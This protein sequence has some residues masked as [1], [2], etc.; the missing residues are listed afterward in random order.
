MKV[1]DRIEVITDLFLGAAYADARFSAEEKRAVCR[2]L[3]DL[4]LTTELPAAVSERIERFDPARFNLLAAAQD[5]VSDPPMNKRRLLELVAQLC[6]A[7]GELDFDEDEYLHSLAHALGMEPAEYQ[8][9]VLDY[10][11]SD[12]RR[13]FE[14]IR[15]SSVDL[16][17]PTLS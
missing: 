15:R 4:L 3:C 2:V 11:I 10:E 12:L 6:V 14:L 9:I 13:S 5:F 16:I 7:D 1:R 8:D 17:P